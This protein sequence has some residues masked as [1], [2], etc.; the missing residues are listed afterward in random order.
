MRQNIPH[1]NLCYTYHEYY[2]VG[3]Q[4]GGIQ[5]IIMDRNNARIDEFNVDYNQ[6]IQEINEAFPQYNLE[7]HNNISQDKNDNTYNIIRLLSNINNLNL[8]SSTSSKDIE[9][10]NILINKVLGYYCSY[11]SKTCVS[12]TLVELNEF[13]KHASLYGSNRNSL[14]TK[15][16][17]LYEEFMIYTPNS[18][19]MY[20]ITSLMDVFQNSEDI[21]D[22]INNNIHTRTTCNILFK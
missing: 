12:I 7:P 13:F 2:N 22:I 10:Y 1:T 5:T 14:H 3:Y 4:H 21:K 19:L 8:S 11:N 15:L 6:I 16:S 9:H 17:A 20:K 18:V